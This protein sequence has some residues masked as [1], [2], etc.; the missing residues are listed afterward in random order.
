MLNEA[1]RIGLKVDELDLEL[2]AM[3]LDLNEYYS[4]MAQRALTDYDELNYHDNEIM[5]IVESE[6]DQIFYQKDKDWHYRKEERRWVPMN[7][8]S[9]WR[10]S[11][12][13]GRKV[14]TKAFHIR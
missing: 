3:L 2:N 12:K 1:K 14:I 7:D 11:I 9:S 5:T 6:K 13:Q 4:E 8:S 10:R